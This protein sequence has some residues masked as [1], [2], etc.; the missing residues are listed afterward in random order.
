MPWKEVSTM[1]LRLEFVTLAQHQAGNFREL[2]RRFGISAKTGYKWRRRFR[3]A[4]SAALADLSRRPHH[5]PD[6]TA[7]ALEQAV[8]ELRRQH[9]AW[10]G[11]KLRARLRAEGVA[12]V[13]AASTITAILG[14]HGLLD[15]DRA[16]QPRDWQRFEHAA[17]NDLWQMDFKGHVAL[18]DG[19]RCHPLTVLDDHARFALGLRACAD[20]RG[21]TVQQELTAIFRVY[22]LPVRLLVDNG[23]PWGHT[24][25]DPYTP[26]TLWLL[27]LG[28]RVTHGRPY[29]PQTQGKDERFHRTLKAELLN[30]GPFGDLTTAQRHFDAWRGVYN[31][32][33][34]HEALALQVPASRYRPSSRPFP[35]ALPAIEYGPDDVVRR[36]Q[37][38][39]WF[40]YRGLDYRVAQALRGQ[41]IALRASS[42]DG[43]WRVWFCH[44]CLGTIDLKEPGRVWRPDP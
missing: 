43:Q 5:S 15:S 18:A 29:H 36:V 17:P 21:T 12:K 22:G 26:L 10:G 44:E 1:S 24:T 35:E 30:R 41:P 16:G 14:R 13:P 34:P 33:R 8:V 3:E 19:R 42:T 37:E 20:E 7:A 9:P 38:G 4:G 2:C 6:R 39:G 32:E 11:R 40:S 25:E 31:L 28:V 23:P 27:R